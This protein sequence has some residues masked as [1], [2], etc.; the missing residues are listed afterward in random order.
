M[1]QVMERNSRVSHTWLVNHWPVQAAVDVT[2]SFAPQPLEF[3]RWGTLKLREPLFQE[4]SRE[5]WQMLWLVT[6]VGGTASGLEIVVWGL[7][8][9]VKLNVSFRITWR[10]IGKM[11]ICSIILNLDTRCKW[12]VSLTTWLPYASKRGPVPME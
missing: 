6:Y 10:H 1:E 7:H 9:Y 2:W 4:N 11:E 3:P 8:A 5:N 12:V